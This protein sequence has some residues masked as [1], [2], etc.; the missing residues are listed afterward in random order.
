MVAHISLHHPKDGKNPHSH[1]LC[2]M[3]K[4]DG[5]TFSAEKATEWNDVAVLCAQRKSWKKAANDALEKTGRP[6]RVDCRSLKDRGID[7]IPEPKVGVAAKAMKRKGALDDPERFRMLRWIKSLNEVRP[8]LRAI[9]KDG[10][11]NQFGVGGT[12]WEKSIL[13]MQ[14]VRERAI[15]GGCCLARAR[16]R[17]TMAASHPAGRICRGKSMAIPEHVK[18]QAM[19]A[20]SHK[21]TTQMIRMYQ[22]KDAA[23]PVLASPVKTAT[24]TRGAIPEHV[25]KQAMDA[26]AHKE[27]TAQIRLV[28]DGGAPMAPLA[29]SQEANRAAQKVSEMHK[30]G[31]D[32][33]A[34]Q[35]AMSKDN[36]GRDHG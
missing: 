27:T 20:V 35:R 3:R 23:A 7:R 10:E 8:H 30:R 4:L 17:G 34:V 33:D 22:N 14:T 9:Q 21:E 13:F 12:W 11:V 25:K 15:H 36:F 19:D 16:P 6:E 31:Q 28:K 29:P 18:K 2:T 26:V 1:I 5:D 32:M 24:A